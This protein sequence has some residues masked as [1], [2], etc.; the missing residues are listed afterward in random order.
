[1]GKFSLI[2]FMTENVLLAIIRVPPTPNL[3]VYSTEKLRRKG[4]RS[5]TE[6]AS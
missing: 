3:Q 5:P 4:V 1:M 6:M 2:S